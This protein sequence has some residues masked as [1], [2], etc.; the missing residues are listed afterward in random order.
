ML[1]IPKLIMKLCGVKFMSVSDP[2]LMRSSNSE[3][4]ETNDFEL[5]CSIFSRVLQPNECAAAARTL[6]ERFGALN[7]VLGADDSEWRSVASLPNLA[8]SELK[9]TRLLMRSILKTEIENRPLLDDLNAVRRFARAILSGKSR[10]EFHALFLDTTYHLLRHE[11]MQVGTVNHVAVYPRELMARALTLNARH[12]ILVHNHPDGTSTPSCA[13]IE[14]TH[15][16]MKAG[17]MLQISILDHII[18]GKNADFS[19]LQH[20]LLKPDEE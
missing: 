20:G 18:I 6:L 11:C 15:Q 17:Q 8:I 10:E 12:L 7:K 13:D 4:C 19:F 2:V 1:F 14:M 3:E 5:L 16:L 9:R